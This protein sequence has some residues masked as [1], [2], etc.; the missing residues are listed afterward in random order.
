MD[1]I[2]CA[3]ATN[4]AFGVDDVE[5]AALIVISAAF[6]AID[7]IGRG[8]RA[9]AEMVSIGRTSA[10]E[11]LRCGVS[12][13]F[14]SSARNGES[15]LA[16]VSTVAA[17]VSCLW[18]TAKLHWPLYDTATRGASADGPPLE[19]EVLRVLAGD[20]ANAAA[21]WAL[22]SRAQRHSLD[23]GVLAEITRLQRAL[24]TMG[25]GRACR[26]LVQVDPVDCRDIAIVTLR[27]GLA[28]G[29]RTTPIDDG[30]IESASTLE[31][32]G[33]LAHYNTDVSIAADLASKFWRI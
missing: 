6:A 23:V 16:A 21:Q 2:E 17:A 5:Q 28:L 20:A 30:S 32:S 27:V 29:A 4:T 10:M 31:R 15:S 18:A 19:R 3:D 12:A 1:Y 25:I 33:E 22:F 24:A 7:T 8:D 14:V 26:L 13:L 9:C 11:A